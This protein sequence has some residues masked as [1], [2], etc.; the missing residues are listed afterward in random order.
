MR[1]LEIVIVA[2]CLSVA[3]SAQA[4]GPAKKA[5][6]TQKKEE[7]VEPKIYHLP[8]SE[9]PV[10]ESLIV[11]AKI[12][13]AW[14]FARAEVFYRRSGSQAYKSTT[15]ERSS[16]GGYAATIPAREVEPP[17]VEYY[18]V[19]KDKQ[20][21]QRQHFAS[22][23]NPHLVTVRGKPETQ[24]MMNDLARHQGNHSRAKVSFTYIDFGK[25]ANMAEGREYSD[26]YWQLELDYTYR[27][28]KIPYYI[29]LGYRRLRST[30]QGSLREPIFGLDQDQIDPGIDFGFAELKFRLDDL[31]GL[32]AKI[33][34]G[35]TREGFAI[36]GGGALRIGYDPGTHVVMIFE[37]AQDL[38]WTAL[39]RLAWDTVEGFPMGASVG[40]TNYP[41]NGD[42]AVQL[43]FD[44]EMRLFE[45]VVLALRTGYQARDYRVGGPAIGGYLIYEF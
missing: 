7:S 28:L 27:I 20:G 39:L 5:K 10:S 6:S 14:H 25:R 44:V 45:P 16:T 43:L 2:V 26:N 23:A 19:S 35:A 17:G 11:K 40:V 36:G 31:V 42:T 8:A 18:I 12:M 13:A 37:G 34:L 22:P 30:S 15:L 21:K 3:W 9:A 32:K 4:K 1:K 29:R 24:R 38:G 41:G 33:I